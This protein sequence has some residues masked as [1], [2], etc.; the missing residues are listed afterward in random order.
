M[1]ILRETIPYVA[2]CTLLC[3]LVC[4]SNGIDNHFTYKMQIILVLYEM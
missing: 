3:A 2:L 4:T 1:Y